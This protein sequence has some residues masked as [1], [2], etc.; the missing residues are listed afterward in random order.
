MGNRQQ[1]IKVSQG[2]NKLATA[3][4]QQATAGL[5]KR[6][7]LISRMG[8]TIGFALGFARISST[9]NKFDSG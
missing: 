3:T 5:F 9:A 8:S 1:Q 7:P 6:T 4:R 2:I